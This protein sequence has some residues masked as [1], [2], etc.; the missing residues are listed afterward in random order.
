MHGEI[1]FTPP[2]KPAFT[3]IPTPE[4]TIN[5]ATNAKLIADSLAL[6]IS[7][8][9]H[10]ADEAQSNPGQINSENLRN[11]YLLRI[12]KLQPLREDF[13]TLYLQF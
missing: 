11:Y 10:L 9:K 7:L 4:L 8:Y 1:S 6:T 5:T 3:K 12:Q 13:E 2:V